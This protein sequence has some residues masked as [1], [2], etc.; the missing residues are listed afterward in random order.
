MYSGFEP[1]DVRTLGDA[2]LRFGE[3]CDNKEGP[4]FRGFLLDEGIRAG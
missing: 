3:G 1:G 2:R 4:S